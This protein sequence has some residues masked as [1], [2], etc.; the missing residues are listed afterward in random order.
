MVRQL[1]LRGKKIYV[2]TVNYESSAQALKFMGVDGIITD[3]PDEISEYVAAR[4]NLFETA[5]QRIAEREF[6]SDFAQGN[7]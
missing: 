3:M 6:D 5:I 4:N 7:Y 1:H 2:W